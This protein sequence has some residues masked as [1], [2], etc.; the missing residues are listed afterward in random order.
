MILYSL[1]ALDWEIWNKRI[2]KTDE[3]VV[4]NFVKGYFSLEKKIEPTKFENSDI[5]G[6][7]KVF[8]QN[9]HWSKI[10]SAKDQNSY[11]GYMNYPLVYS[12]N[13]YS[14][15]TSKY[16]FSIYDKK[17]NTIKHWFPTDDPE[18]LAGEYYL[19]LDTFN[20]VIY[21]MARIR[22]HIPPWSREKRQIYL[23]KDE[24]KTWNKDEELTQIFN[25]YDFRSLEILDRNHALGY[26]KRWVKHKY[27]EY[28]VDQGIYY[29][30]KNMQIVDSLKMPNDPVSNNGFAVNYQY[31]F[32]VENDTVF[33]GAWSHSKPNFQPI[34]VKTDGNWN[35]TS[36]KITR[37][38]R[39]SDS[40]I[41]KDS[42]RDYQNFQLINNRELVFKNGSGTLKL[43]YEIDK[44]QNDVYIWENGKRIY[45]INYRNYYGASSLFSLLSF[46]GGTSWYIYPQELYEKNPHI[47][48][49]IN[50]QNEILLYNLYKLY[51]AFYKFSPL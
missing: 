33:L 20:E 3:R 19:C 41:E 44:K 29:L 7:S 25:K 27:K 36:K 37:R 12:D 45:L 18:L 49:E 48:M 30:L 15:E 11:Y 40:D 35:F 43:N 46:D 50:E 21:Q 51:K 28:N 38:Y 32:S 16:I 6:N 9:P 42:I 31:G 39:N 10:F 4:N 26:T 2:D 13:N 23:S 8:Y 1:S 5:L 22:N 47:F 17:K 34:I 24:G 14:D